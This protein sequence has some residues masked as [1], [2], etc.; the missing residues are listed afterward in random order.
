M[1]ALGSRLSWDSI[2]KRQQ[3]DT[4]RYTHARRGPEAPHSTMAEAKKSAF[5]L[6]ALLCHGLSIGEAQTCEGSK[7]AYEASGFSV[8]DVPDQPIQGN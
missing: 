4:P 3:S 7:A 2:H 6:L 1:L 8:E 5:L